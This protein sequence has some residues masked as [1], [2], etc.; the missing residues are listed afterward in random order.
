MSL[1]FNIRHLEQR[2]LSLKGELP[3]SELGLEN[4]DELVHAEEPLSYDIELQRLDDAV[5]AQGSLRLRLRC[6]CARCLKSYADELTLPNWTCH[7]PLKGE[8]KVEVVNDSVDLTPFIREDIVLS[9]PQ[10]PLCEPECKGLPSP[11]KGLATGELEKKVS[12][13]AWAELNKLKL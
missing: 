10:H 13:S 3:P 11:Q 8:E 1:K 9:L 2:N 4:L 12:S 7:L 5:L 6:E